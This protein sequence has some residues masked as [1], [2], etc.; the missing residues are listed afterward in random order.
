MDKL[1]INVG[2]TKKITTELKY[3]AGPLY[4]SYLEA[5]KAS[6]P[7]FLMDDFFEISYLGYFP[8]KD[9]EEPIYYGVLKEEDGYRPFITNKTEDIDNVVNNA[10]YRI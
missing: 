5:Q 9:L 7:V 6:Q 10:I 4:K 3:M 1:K 8:T 2:N